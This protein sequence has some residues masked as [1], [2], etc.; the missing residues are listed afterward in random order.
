MIEILFDGQMEGVFNRGM[1][2]YEKKFGLA[3]AHKITSGWRPALDPRVKEKYPNYCQLI[4]DCW[5]HKPRHRP[6]FTR[7]LSYLLALQKMVDIGKDRE[8]L[9]GDNYGS[10]DSSSLSGTSATSSLRSEMTDN[11]STLNASFRGNTVEGRMR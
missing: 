7:I 9:G 4:E 8:K 10:S 6:Q 11:N 1:K 2:D 3:I 5:Q